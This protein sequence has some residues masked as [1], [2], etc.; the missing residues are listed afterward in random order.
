MHFSQ[1]EPGR[2]NPRRILVAEDDGIT[3]RI[4]EHWL[5]VLGFEV[6]S[7]TDGNEAWAVLQGPNPP[8]LILMDWVMPGIDG[9]ELCRRLRET[10]GAYYHYILMMTGRSDLS[11]VVHAL[12]S[13]A[14]DCLTK[15]F[16][17]P[18]LKAR[19]GVACRILDLQDQLIEAREEI[20][21]QAMKDTLTGLWNRAAFTEMFERELDR[22]K[23]N[24][25][26]TALLLLDLDHFKKVNDMHGHMTG[27]AVL[28]KAARLLRENVRAYDFVGRYGGEEFFIAFPNC[29]AEQAKEHAERIRQAVAATPIRAG[30][31]E[32]TL[33]FS[34]GAAVADAKQGS[35]D[36]TLAATDVALHRAKNS[37]RNCVVSCRRAPEEV[38]TF[39]GK[40][41]ACCASCDPEISRKCTNVGRGFAGIPG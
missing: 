38:F 11:H 21:E 18:E 24:Q 32:I 31:A 37:G 9:I 4:L 30:S 17:Q 1:P 23:R 26:Q 12:E 10:Q 3:R 16:E 14:D 20:R 27:D 41:E 28:R 25:G 40:P 19:L 15:P 2:D 29:D 5:G 36:A 13:G 39:Q 33:S 34:I 7:A 8:E 22:A 6:I 35:I